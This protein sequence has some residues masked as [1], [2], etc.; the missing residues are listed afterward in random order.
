MPSQNN[1]SST[2]DM[3]SGSIDKVAS[4][5]LSVGITTPPIVLQVLLLLLSLGFLYLTIRKVINT[6]KW[7]I[8]EVLQTATFTVI[9]AAVLLSWAEQTLH[10]FP[11]QIDGTVKLLKDSTKIAS[12]MRVEI[13]DVMGS[14]ISPDVGL[15][16]TTNGRFL[17]YY[18]SE[19]GVRP[20]LLRI[21]TPECSQD[22]PLSRDEL[23][24]GEV[25]IPFNCAGKS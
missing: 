18:P 19:F 12:D 20:Y 15:V 9:A 21:I 7:N 4:V 1:V 10:P 3:I 13:H 22:Y 8:A 2:L 16:S 17:M 5:L 25:T 11:G 23:R 24:R 14:K 6:K